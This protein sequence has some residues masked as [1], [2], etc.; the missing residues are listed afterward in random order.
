MS[1]YPPATIVCIDCYLNSKKGPS[2][3]CI[4][5]IA[6]VLPPGQKIPDAEE[7]QEMVFNK[8]GHDITD[9]TVEVVEDQRYQN[10]DN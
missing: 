5:H 6:L 10:T 7:I 4:L 9:V 8:F 1:F 3:P 2:I